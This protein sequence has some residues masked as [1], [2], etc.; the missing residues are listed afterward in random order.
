MALDNLLEVTTVG[1][2]CSL[3]IPD[4]KVEKKSVLKCQVKIASIKNLIDGKTNSE[5]KSEYDADGLNPITDEQIT[6][7]KSKITDAEAWVETHKDLL[8]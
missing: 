1:L 4:S 2:T 6:S 7:V 8:D 5:I 3:N